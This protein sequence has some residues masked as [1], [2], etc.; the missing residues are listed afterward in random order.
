MAKGIDRAVPFKKID[1]LKRLREFGYTFVGRYLTKNRYSWKALSK[2]EAKLITSADMY[3]VCVYQNSGNRHDYFNFLQGR[4]DAIDAIDAANRVG[5]PADG[6]IYFSVDCNT[7]THIEPMIEYFKG[8]SDIMSKTEH[9]VGVYGCYR[10]CVVIPKI[11]P[12]VTHKWQTVAWSKG[13]KCEFNLYQH[14]IDTYI[15]EDKKMVGYDLNLSNGNGGGW[16]Y[17]GGDE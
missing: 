11:V 10:T 17:I 7:E 12:L 15:P 13:R 8:V 6:V 9:K 2:Q 4:K 14:K 5:M 1:E 16:K 3:V